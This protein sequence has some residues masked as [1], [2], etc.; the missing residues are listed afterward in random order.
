VTISV[1]TATW[2]PAVEQLTAAAVLARADRTLY[3][4]KAA[5]KNR[6]VGYAQSLAT[7]DEFEAAIAR[8]LADGDFELHYQPIV[9]LG[10]GQVSGFEA[11]IRW[12]R[13]GHG[14]VPPDQ[15]IPVAEASGLICD[16]GRWVLGEAAG[17]L[18]RWTR[19]GLDPDG[20]LRVAI[21]IS[22]RHLTDSAI[23]DDVRRAVTENHIAAH[24]LELE[25]T[26]TTLT[27]TAHAV[28]CLTGL[29][30]LGVRTAID[31]FG[32]GYT[33][34]GQLPALPFDT[35]KIDRSFVAATH[36]SHRNLTALMIEAAHAFQLTVTAE[37]VEDA[38]TLD[39]LRDLGC[40][41]AQGYLLARPMP[42]ADVPAWLATWNKHTRSALL[43]DTNERPAHLVPAAREG[44]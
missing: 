43:P 29:R 18:A 11:L 16:L 39:A 17:Q 28:A 38:G 14:R 35:L 36:E 23:V 5:G 15:F 4:A 24:R 21:N 32:T 31:D 33:S 34:I 41:S 30:T 19:D 9:A 27:D 1:G 12:N 2:L 13:P 42:A 26:E 37:G 8:S 25:I 20:T 22:G 10:A 44:H 3:A 6:A 7:Q 40:D